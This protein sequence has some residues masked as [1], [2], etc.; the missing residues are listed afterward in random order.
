MRRR[1]PYK[2][3]YPI[4]VLV[5]LEEKQASVWQIFSKMVKPLLTIRVGNDRKATYNFHESIVDALRP[6]VRE[7]VRTVVVVAPA[8]TNY[9]KGF[10][11]HVK[12]HHSW[13]TQENG[14]CFATFGELTGVA[15]TIDQV[16]D[17]LKTQEFSS[18]LL[19]IRSKDADRIIDK[20]EKHI[21][22]LDSNNT[23]LYSLEEIEELVNRWNGRGNPTPE[24]VTL[25]DKY[26]AESKQ[27]NRVNRLLQISKNKNI[28]TRIVDA[29]TEAGMRINQF[30]GLICLTRKSD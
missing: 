12:K 8:K 29:D 24:Y 26:L 23:M 28:K 3:G 5:G 1:Q 9:S 2:R 30:G 19:D 25:T 21:N 17:I 20:L 16:S 22:R 18:K 13:L 7:G 6:I 15:N 14:S 27:K 4:G 11:G 10:I